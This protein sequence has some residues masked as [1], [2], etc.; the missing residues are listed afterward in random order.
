[1]VEG[2]RLLGNEG[3][4]NLQ[5]DNDYVDMTFFKNKLKELKDENRSSKIIAE[6]SRHRSPQVKRSIGFLM[7]VQHKLE[8]LAEVT[9]QQQNLFF[10]KQTV[11]VNAF[12]EVTNLINSTKELLS[13]E[14]LK[15]QMASKSATG[16]KT[17]QLYE[18]DN[19]FEDDPEAEHKSKKFRA[20]DRS[21]KFVLNRGRGNGAFRG[22]NN[23]GRGGGRGGFG[24][25]NEGS[26]GS[27]G[28]RG[29]LQNSSRF[30]SSNYQLGPC[31]NCNEMGHKISQC[32]K[33]KK[34]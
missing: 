4:G 24:G 1:M 5:I 29:G 32:T 16:W 18:E 26:S 6:K 3:A 27:G 22:F 14:I 30:N 9:G 11:N 34:Q 25:N 15:N 13:D 33:P 19:L 20:A 12:A 17:V 10:N 31:F 2:V 8:D 21:A 7:K 23:R 28:F